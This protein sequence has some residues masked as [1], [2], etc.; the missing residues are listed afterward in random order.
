MLPVNWESGWPVILP[1]H[2]PVPLT[3]KKP[4]LPA[5]K[6]AE[7]LTTGNI[8]FTDNFDSDALAFRW[9][10][11]RAPTSTW[12]AT[13]KAAKALFLEP[14]ADL[15]SGRGNP[16]YLA[17]RQ[18]NNDF[19]CAVTLAAQP[20]TTNCTAGL[21]AFQNEGH[22]FAINVKI[23]DGHLAEVSLDQ[24]ATAGGFGRRGQDGGNAA[25]PAPVAT[26]KLPEN[27]ASIELKIEGAGPVT[28]CYYKTGNGEFSQLG[29]DL[30]SSLLSTD[31]AGGFQGVTLGVFARLNPET[32]A[33]QATNP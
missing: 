19:T 26:Q 15:L 33:P 30:R 29:G 5:D 23:S 32:P 28:R 22:Y 12:Y 27:T 16:S 10:G 1:P 21:A 25:E 7:V 24:H 13:S 17:V 2:T 14:R 11:L 4:N 3:V 6:P 8:A 31:T 18:Q 9:V 20:K